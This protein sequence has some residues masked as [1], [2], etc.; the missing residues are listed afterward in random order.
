MPPKVVDVEV[1]CPPDTLGGLAGPGGFHALIRWHGIPVAPLTG[2]LRGGDGADVTATIATRHWRVLMRRRLRAA[3]QTS[4]LRHDVRLEDLAR[5]APPPYAGP[6]P[7]VTV[8]VCTRD[9]AT[10][11]TVCLDALMELDYPALDLVVIDNAPSTD[12]TARLL[13]ARYPRARYVCEPRPGLDWARNRAIQEARGEIL[14]FTDD[15]AVVDRGWVTALVRV[16]TEDPE[17]MAVTGLVV[18]YELETA[19]QQLFE[20]YGGFG[21][22]YEREWH[23]VSRRPDRPDI[24]HIGAGL[25]GTGANMA[26]RRRVFETIGA[27]DPALDVGTPTRGG[28]DLDM[29]FRVVHNGLLLVY[30][31]AAIVRH[32]HRRS[33]GE[34]YQQIVGWGSGFY[35]YL[36]RN[37]VLTPAARG[38]LLR[39][40]LWYFWRRYVRRLLASLF[41]PPVVPRALILAELRGALT[42]VSRYR[43][44]RAAAARIASASPSLVSSQADRS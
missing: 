2:Q 1:S 4:G 38:P 8:A 7:L 18:P 37:L 17:A 3:L 9:R 34:L 32:R 36:A 29:F 31:P 39:F 22:G 20:R 5:A 14:A 35:A 26:Y 24:L 27:F 43:R 33:Q 42:G 41:V 13:A 44:A 25:Y 30:E 10:E 40:G 15:D 16:F 19:A 21:R 12:A 28:G 6:F 23:S 11:L